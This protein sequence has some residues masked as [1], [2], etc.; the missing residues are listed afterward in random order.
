MGY[1][2]LEGV[3]GG[4]RGCM[5]L[6]GVTEIVVKSRSVKRNAKNARGTGERQGGGASLSH[7]YSRHRPLSARA[8]YFRFA[9]FNTSA[10]YYLRT[11]HRLGI[12][13]GYKWLPEVTRGYRRL[14]WIAIAY[15]VVTTRNYLTVLATHNCNKS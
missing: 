6:Q 10:L 13:G 5:G 7:F 2:R 11:W 12:T 14:S 8:S 3:T 1:R 15:R 9:R 4:T